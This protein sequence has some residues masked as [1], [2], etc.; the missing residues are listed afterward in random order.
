[1]MHTLLQAFEPVS[2]LV[3]RGAVAGLFAVVGAHAAAQ[4]SQAPGVQQP[5]APAVQLPQAA[6]SADYLIGPGDTLQVFVWGQPDL[7]VTVQVRPDGWWA[8]CSRHGVQDSKD[9]DE[10]R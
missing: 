10:R 4:Q 3:R 9:L 6:V 7:S 8:K 2:A 5:P 1:M